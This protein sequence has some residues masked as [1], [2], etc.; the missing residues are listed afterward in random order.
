[1]LYTVFSLIHN[2]VHSIRIVSVELHLYSYWETTDC[3]SRYRKDGGLC[4]LDYR[5]DCA[6][7]FVQFLFI[8]G[9][10]KDLRYRYYLYYCFYGFYVKHLE[11]PFFYEMCYI[12][13]VLLWLLLLSNGQIIF[14]CSTIILDHSQMCV[15]LTPSLCM[16]RW[17]YLP[18]I[19]LVWKM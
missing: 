4:V 3:G 10:H 18:L 2:V 16:T 1:M 13:K 6:L 19:R 9:N 8:L 14:L 12:N 5:K 7:C 15:R 11:L 17:N